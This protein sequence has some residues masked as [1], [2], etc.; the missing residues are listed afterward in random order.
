M[1]KALIDLTEAILL[2]STYFEA[3][4][5]RARIWIKM[6]EYYAAVED[7]EKYKELNGAKPVTRFIKLYKFLSMLQALK[8]R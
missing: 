4:Y 6:K 5:N 8:R 1:D 3:Y 2:R 7:F